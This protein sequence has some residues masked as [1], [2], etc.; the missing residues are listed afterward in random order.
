MPS[1]SVF[2]DMLCAIQKSSRFAKQ[3]QRRMHMTRHGPAIALTVFITRTLKGVS[4]MTSVMSGSGNAQGKQWETQQ[5][6]HSDRVVVVRPTTETMSRQQLPYYVGISE[7]TAGAKNL[8]M[9]LIIIP[10]GGA[11]EPQLRK[12][13]ETAI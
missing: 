8:S 9:N 1:L 7:V 5:D 3:N 2:E 12:G 11:A 4:Q 13:Y 10:P 6:D